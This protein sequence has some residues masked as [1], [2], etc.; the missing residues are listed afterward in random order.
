MPVSD[1]D[2]KYPILYH[3]HANV[4]HQYDGSSYRKLA[5]ISSSRRVIHA[6][7]V[8]SIPSTSILG[9]A[10]DIIKIRN[11]TLTAR[12]TPDNQR[13]SESTSTIFHPRFC[14]LRKWAA[15]LFQHLVIFD[16]H[17]PLLAQS[18]LMVV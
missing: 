3:A 15:D 16:E 5:I 17:L 2:Q 8:N 6:T 4:I 14:Q 10:V 18:N 1:R 13:L 12:L 7:I 9:R 11:N